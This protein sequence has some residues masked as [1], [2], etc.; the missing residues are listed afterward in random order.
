MQLVHIANTDFE[1]EL[2]EPPNF[3]SI[4]QAWGLHPLCLQLQFVPLLYADSKDLIVVTHKPDPQFMS[5]YS[6]LNWRHGNSPPQLVSFDEC[7]LN[8]EGSCIS[9]GASKRVE[10]WCRSKKIDYSMPDWEVVK[11]I[12]SKAFSFSLASE[13]M[14]SALI[15]DESD[16]KHWLENVPGKRV[17]KT[18]F[19]LSGRGHYFIHDYSPVDKIFKFCEKEWLK[20]RPLIGEPWVERVF[21]FSTQWLLDKKEG[22]RLIG[23][24]V[25]EVNEKGVYQ[26]TL[27]GSEKKLFGDY[28]SFLEEHKEVARKVLQKVLDKGFFGNLGVDAFLYRD[29]N[30]KICLRSI[31]EINGRQTMSLA[32]LLFQKKWFPDNVVRMYFVSLSGREQ[33]LLP[34]KIIGEDGK[35]INFTKK[36]TFSLIT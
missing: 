13:L 9:W 4:P 36:L 21:D 35:E 6:N 8:T 31:V 2:V 17:L 30:G 1:F 11:Q 32:A 3:L 19:G 10:D 14:G 16:L 29:I 23:P 5:Q 33:S 26:A 15:W 24:T 20:E 28:H 27:A 12:N 7:L 34:M 25:F 22:I 18:C